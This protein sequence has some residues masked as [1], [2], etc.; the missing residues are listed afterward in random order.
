MTTLSH[1]NS[2][3]AR[4][5]TTD[6]AGNVTGVT[7]QDFTIADLANFS[8]PGGTAGQVLTTDGTGVL[9][10]ANVTGGG[11][12]ISVGTGGSETFI[13]TA[14]Q[15]LFTVASVP[16]GTVGMTVN[17]V[18]VATTAATNVGTAVTYVPAQNAGYVLKAGDRVVLSYIYGS[19][20]VGD[21]AGL[22]DVTITTPAAGQVLAFDAGTSKWVNVPGATSFGLVA[23]GTSNVSIANN[24]NVTVGVTGSA[25]VATFSSGGVTIAG[26]L[27]VT[28]ANVSLGD[29][30]NVTITGGTAGQAL[31]S[32]GGGDVAFQNSTRIVTNVFMAGT[33]TIL[34]GYVAVPIIHNEK[35]Y[36]PQNLY[37]VITG[38]FQPKIAGWYQ[39]YASA[40]AFTFASSEAG[41]V[42]EHSVDGGIATM[43][44]IGPVTMNATGIAYFNG[45][46]DY[47]FVTV[48]SAQAGTRGQNRTKTS[49]VATYLSI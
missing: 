22:S 44:V 24:G 20:S 34:A 40:D 27:S 1:T 30:A 16:N 41:I 9:S 8:L 21:I 36:D 33:L 28:G 37:N 18:Q 43:G 42:I 32:L 7:V 11:G 13:A 10:W 14:G 19:T 3:F 4:I 47:A 49:F 46:T 38:R 45:T 23:N 25:N 15:V 35:L 12:T 17:G 6:A 2:E 39:I 5:A 26:N 48:R 31:V 29:V